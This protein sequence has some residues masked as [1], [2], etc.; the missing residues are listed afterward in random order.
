MKDDKQIQK[1]GKNSRQIQ[2]NNIIISNGIEEKRARE[3]FMEMFDVARRDLTKEAYEIAE[4]RVEQFENEL[5]SKMERVD[6][7]INAFADPDFQFLLTNAHRTAATTNREKDY[8]LLSELLLR[9]VQRG[10][11][12]YIRAGIGR[13]VEIVDDISDEALLGLTTAFAIEKYLPVTG[14]MKEGLSVL[15][16]LFKEICYANLPEGT[17]WL[18]HLEILDAIRISSFGSL[19]KLEEYFS[20]R[21]AGYCK[22]GIKKE[23]DDYSLAVDMLKEKGL[24]LSLLCDHEINEGYV[25]IPIINEQQIDEICIRNV[26]NEL[27]SS[28]V[29]VMDLTMQQKEVLHKIY[30]MYDNNQELLHM[31]KINF[32]KEL[33]NYQYLSIIKDWWN[34]IPLSFEMTGVGRV[35]GHANAKRV[36]ETLPDLY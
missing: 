28:R 3:I 16:I 20:E 13:A 8:A 31:V 15:N 9:R 36:Y 1:A 34:K 32:Y 5:I 19:K 26:M 14:R 6:G 4:Q 35:L 23:S 11:N 22:V 17:D 27:G 30:S 21:M 25:R 2:A 10:N 7:A 12:R 18:E 29:E 24:P 33:E